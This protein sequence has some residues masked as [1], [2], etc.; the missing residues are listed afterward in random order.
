VLPRRP[1][2]VGLS[3]PDGWA[4]ALPPACFAATVAALA[5]HP[6]LALAVVAVAGIGVPLLGALALAL[7]ARGGRPGRAPIVVPLLALA[8]LNAGIAGELAAITLVM[9]SCVALGSLLAAT[10]RIRGLAIGALLVAALDLA[11]VHVGSIRL[12]TT[13][14]LDASTRHLPDFAQPVLGHMTIGYSD[15]LVAALAGAVAARHPS[16]QTA[17]AVATT[18]FALAQYALS[19]NGELLPSTVPVAVALLAAT[20][21]ARVGARRARVA[22][23]AR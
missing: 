4:V 1:R 14:L 12:A 18:T 11:L 21:A 15:F 7:F 6:S 22:P 2:R 23:V 8:A 9:L 19:A 17:V 10:A 16:R 20:V 13:A 3:L 5:L